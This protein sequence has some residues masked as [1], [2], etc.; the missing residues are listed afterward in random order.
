MRREEK[1]VV[2]AKS[3]DF[4]GI[5]EAYGVDPVIA[6][7]VRNREVAES[8]LDAYF[9]PSAK[10]LHDPA[11]LKDA[12][13]AVA[14]L[15]KKIGEQKKIRII[16]DYDID[17][18]F[19]TYIL[20]HGL[21]ACGAVV[22]YRL[23]HRVS[24]GYGLNQ[25]LIDEA[26][27]AG[28]DTI[29]TCD[30]GIA[31][32]DEI[33]YA[34]RLGLTVIVT[35]HHEI[36][37][38]WEGE[39]AF[40]VLPQADAVVDPKQPGCAYPFS[41]ICGAVVAWKVL[42]LLQRAYGRAEDWKQYLG[43]AAF[44]TV[45]DVMELRGENRTITALGLEE[46]RHT[47]H[48][49]LRAL[50]VQNE[51]TCAELQAYHIGYVIGPCINASGR[52][53][54]AKRALE[55]LLE[56]DSARATLRAQ[57]LVALNESRKDLTAAGTEEAVQQVESRQLWRKQVL[58]VFLP[59]CH[60]SLA[61][62][63][64]GRLR[65]R[66]YR[67]T[68]V[69]TRSEGCVKG[70]G[71]SIPAYHMYEKLSRVGGMLL[72][73][74]GH[75]MAAGLSI[76]EQNVS[77][78]ADALNADAGL[79]EAELT[80]KICIDVPMP[81]TYI[82]EQLIEQLAVLEPCGN[83]N[84]KP[85]F[86]DRRLT[87]KRAYYIGKERNMLKLQLFCGNGYMDALYFGDAEEFLDYYRERFGAEQVDALLCGRPQQIQFAFIYYPQINRYQGESSVQIVIR[88]YA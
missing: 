78:F 10:N 58:V 66:Y 9:H 36:P 75:A 86:A 52:L 84:E 80:E 41:G 62:I 76:E 88:R 63:I 64:A 30:N 45:G 33:A 55:L 1:W 82:S 39:Q 48:V 5:G 13:K 14:L 61:G 29:L 16:G 77:A 34:K 51:F 85:V 44:A 69:L 21:R 79:S 59:D 35:D 47:N 4:N 31:A 15:Q 26:Y 43:C 71:R 74:G 8:E 83:G 50:I 87:A 17:G 37:L 70:S 38:R 46:L 65:E 12:E 60:E 24:D 54:T 3:A 19:A 40:P 42:Q 23:P 2:L 53:D 73:F 6:R 67:P 20:Y 7:I 72:K 25:K 28:C 57:E 49:G 32:A 22:D 68:F 27:E 11:L 81:L 56:E 18:I